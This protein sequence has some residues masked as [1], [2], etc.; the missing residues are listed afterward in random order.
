MKKIFTSI[1]MAL[2]LAASSFNASAQQ[3][4]QLSDAQKQEIQQKVLPVVFEQIKEQAGIDILGWAQPKLTAD[5]LGSLPILG[6]L[7]NGLRADVAPYSVQPD[8]IIL[9]SNL[10]NAP[11]LQAGK[12]G[13]FTSD[14]KIVF[15]DYQEP[16][17]SLISALLG[18]DRGLSI[19]IPSKITA[20][21]GLLKLLTVNIDTEENSSLLNFSTDIQIGVMTREPVSAL[22]LSF[23]QNSETYGFDFNV[24]INDGMISLWDLMKNTLQLPLPTLPNR[25]YCISIDL[26]TGLSTMVF[27]IS[28]TGINKEDDSTVNLGKADLAIA[29]TEGA[30]PVQYI[31]VTSYNDDETNAESAWNRFMFNMAQANQNIVLTID[32]Y[33]YEN[34][35]WE[36][37]SSN[38]KRYTITMSDNTVNVSNVQSARYLRVVTQNV[39]SQL[40]NEGEVSSVCDVY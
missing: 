40:A 30:F 19:K 16:D 4:T 34:G 39:I 11:L 22:N 18:M 9:S 15:E 35:N 20:T 5:Y 37:S 32:Q 17:L 36:G 31:N 8:S 27:P 24:K 28:L 6:G 1:S 12:P 25:D 2:C 14:L 21:S 38:E 23:G 10:L 26:M 13:F 29:T 33:K 3:A 7:N